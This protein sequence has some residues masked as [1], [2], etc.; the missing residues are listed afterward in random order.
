[1]VERIEDRLPPDARV[2][3]AI[4]RSRSKHD[5]HRSGALVRALSDLGPNELVGAK[6]LVKEEW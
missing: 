3:F 2:R 4:D 6:D 1:M 5:L